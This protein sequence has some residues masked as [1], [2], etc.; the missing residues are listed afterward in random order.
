MKQKLLEIIVEEK[1]QIEMIINKDL[2]YFTEIEKNRIDA[3]LCEKK[4]IIRKLE[5]LI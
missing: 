4:R 5:S 1:R 3:A 2:Q